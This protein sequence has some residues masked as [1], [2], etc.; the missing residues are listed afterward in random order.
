MQA[1]NSE[2]MGNRR[3]VDYYF[4]F[5]SFIELNSIALY[6]GVGLWSVEKCGNK[7]YLIKYQLGRNLESFTLF[8][9]MHL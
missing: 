9:N 8:T 7:L 4:H 6:F 3:I 1:H 5:G 2:R